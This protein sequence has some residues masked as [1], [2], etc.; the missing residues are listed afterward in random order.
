MYTSNP[1][2]KPEVDER[3]REAVLHASAVAMAKKMYSTQQ[4][5]FDNSAHKNDQGGTRPR[6]ADS[7]QVRP[8]HFNNLQEAAYRLAQERLAKLQDEHQR[9]RGYQDYYGAGASP[10]SPGRKFTKLGKARRRSSSDSDVAGPGNEDDRQRSRQIHNQMSLFSTRLSEV[11]ES[12]RARDRDALLAAAQRNVKAAMEGMDEKVSRDTG[13]VTSAKLSQWE[14]RAHA[15]AQARSDERKGAGPAAG[16]VDLGSGQY[17]DRERV[18]QIAAKRVQPLLDEINEKAELE[19]KRILALREEQEKKRL[20]WEAEKARN[21]EV[22][23][24]QRKLKEE[25]KA[26]RGELKQE[27]KARKEEEKAAKAEERRLAREEKDH[28]SEAPPGAARQPNEESTSHRH[29]IL[30]F[31]PKIQT[32]SPSAGHVRGE[33]SPLSPSSNTSPESAN[34]SPTSRVKNWLKSRLSKPRAKSIS[35]NNSKSSDAGN[36]KG[37]GGF[38]GGHRLKRLHPDG[39]GSMTSLSEERSASMREVALA[40]RASA[41]VV[42]SDGPGENSGSKIIAPTTAVSGT[43]SPRSAGGSASSDDG[44]SYDLEGRDRADMSSGAPE[45]EGIAP[46]KA[47]SD[48]AGAGSGVTPRSSLGSGNRDSK[49]IEIID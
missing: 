2:V 27:A 46:P 4:K 30:P 16:Q 9:N 25:E 12:Q 48:P 1:P 38:L 14:L 43:G 39:T 41:P 44:A 42:A 17:M 5:A 23:E 32:K 37:S 49:F 21:A 45:L 47:I 7:D 34:E 20:E 18:E 13:R 10:V 8:M 31:T 40:G 15:T 11:D 22:K 6:S 35:G 3:N 28:E 24:N 26:R 36:G 33:P 29:R 19:R